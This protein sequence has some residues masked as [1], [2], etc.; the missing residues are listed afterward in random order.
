MAFDGEYCTIFQS[1]NHQQTNDVI[2][3]TACS[4]VD[5]FMANMRLRYGNKSPSVAITKLLGDQALSSKLN[6][7]SFTGIGYPARSPRRFTGCAFTA[8]MPFGRVTVIAPLFPD[9]S[10][11]SR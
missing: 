8:L 5:P 3:T 9:D 11:P 4:A 7:P 6:L 2:S 10:P 1:A